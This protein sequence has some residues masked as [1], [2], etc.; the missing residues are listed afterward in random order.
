MLELAP[1]MKSPW[2]GLFG[3]LDQGIPA[4]QVEELRRA[5]AAA[6]V[7]TEVMRYPNGKHGFHCDDRPAVYDRDSAVDGWART[8]AFI[9]D[10]I[11]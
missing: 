11:G 1:T 6:G 7:P 10:R 5:T 9:A 4:D 8:L 2:L 3:D